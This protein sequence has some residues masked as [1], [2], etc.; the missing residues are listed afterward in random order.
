M[1]AGTS[2]ST[3]RIHPGRRSI[4][5]PHIPVDALSDTHF[6][7]VD[8]IR[9]WLN[10]FIVS[11]NITFFRDEIHHLLEKWLKVIESNGE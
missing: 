2:R 11:K 5:L 6:Q 10:D 3:R 4:R 7:S 9:K 1:L 8:E